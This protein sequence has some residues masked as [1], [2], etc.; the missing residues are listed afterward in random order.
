[1]REPKH[2]CAKDLLEIGLSITLSK[3]KTVKMAGHCNINAGTRIAYNVHV[4][5]TV[6][7]CY[8]SLCYGSQHSYKGIIFQTLK[9]E[10]E[11]Q[12]TLYTVQCTVQ[13]CYISFCYS[14]QPFIQG[15][16]ISDF[17]TR[18]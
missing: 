14:S 8:I 11:V 13:C 2:H 15:N 3:L 6:Q 18:G 4:Q 17:E 7:R 12:C 5:C 10:V 16:Y 1:M 9:Q